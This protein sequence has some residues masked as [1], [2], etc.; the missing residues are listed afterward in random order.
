MPVAGTEPGR[1]DPPPRGRCTR[2]SAPTA[3]TATALSPH[4]LPRALPPRRAA[5]TARTAR[6]PLPSRL[7]HERKGT[8][9]CAGRCT[10]CAARQRALHCTCCTPGA[11]CTAPPAPYPPELHPLPA[12]H[13]HCTRCPPG[14]PLQHPV[15]ALQVLHRTLHPPK[16]TI[17]HAAHT[18]PLQPLVRPRA[19]QS[20]QHACYNTRGT[21]RNAHCNTARTAPHTSLA[22]AVTR[23]H[24]L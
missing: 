14:T 9:R 3:T 12:L 22:H 2:R 8:A 1:A 15:H 17:L 6:S 11:R 24:M 4:T 21:S 19:A 23:C 10:G 5:V 20:L 18:H 13:C 16:G 7:L